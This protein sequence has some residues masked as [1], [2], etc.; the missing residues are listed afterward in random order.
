MN[1][2]LQRYIYN[3][4]LNKFTE[5][6]KHNNGRFLLIVP[7]KDHH[8]FNVGFDQIAD[9]NKFEADYSRLTT[10]IV[11]RNSSRFKKIIRKI[12]GRFK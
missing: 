1:I 7:G 4:D 10:N 3:V 11:E 8:Y 6:V 12:V 9:C 2:T 5:T